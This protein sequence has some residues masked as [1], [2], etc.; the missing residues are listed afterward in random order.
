LFAFPEFATFKGFSS[1]MGLTLRR[2]RALENA[3]KAR[4]TIILVIAPARRDRAE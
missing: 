3:K 4:T 1:L 2:G